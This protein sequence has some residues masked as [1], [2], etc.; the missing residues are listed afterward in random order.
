M[1][2]ATNTETEQEHGK[3]REHPPFKFTVDGRQFESNV[4]V[5][6]GGQIKA[7]ASVDPSFGLFLEAR[8]HAPDQQIGD[9]QSVD[10]REKGKEHFYTAPPA[11]FGC[12]R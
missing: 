7:R 11:N 9:G 4:P 2:E 3:G 12:V 10:L 8:G 5:L 1:S 6:T